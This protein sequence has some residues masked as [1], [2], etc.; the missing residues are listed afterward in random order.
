VSSRSLATV[1]LLLG[2]LSATTCGDSVGPEGTTLAE[3]TWGGDDAAV[4]VD[5]TWVHVHFACTNG[6]FP[7]PVVLDAQARF[8]VSGEYLLH[9]YPVAVGP[10]MP[11][12]L[13]GV[14]RGRDLTVTVA[15]NDT[16][17]KEL[18]VLGPTTVRLGQEPQM[19]ICPICAPPPFGLLP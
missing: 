5:A 11:A 12:Q 4:L 14:V 2:S 18:V 6:Y 1:A 19:Q 13:A 16:V 7:A 10:S 3:G 8:T 17:A 9:V 15:V